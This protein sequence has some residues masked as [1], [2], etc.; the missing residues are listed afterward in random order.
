MKEN[1][2]NQNLNR[3]LTLKKQPA[4]DPQVKRPAYAAILGEATIARIEPRAPAACGLPKAGFVI[5]WEN[6]PHPDC[7]ADTLTQVRRILHAKIEKFVVLGLSLHPD[8]QSDFWYG[9]AP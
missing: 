1:Y 3:L 8:A 5:Y 9:G 7:N 2:A 4:A 6:S